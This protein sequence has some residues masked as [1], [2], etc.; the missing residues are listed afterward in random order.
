MKHPKKIVIYHKNYVD[1]KIPNWAKRSIAH[2]RALQWSGNE[3]FDN[4][5]DLGN[6]YIRLF[7]KASLEKKK[8]QMKKFRKDISGVSNWSKVDLEIYDD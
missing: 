3:F 8:K 4:T 5:E 6:G 1:Y 2:W 7:S